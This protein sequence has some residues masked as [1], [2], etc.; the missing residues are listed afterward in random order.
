MRS[1]KNATLVGMSATVSCISAHPGLW[2]HCVSSA[3]IVQEAALPDILAWARKGLSTSNNSNASKVKLQWDTVA[4]V[5]HSRGGD[6]AYHQ[7]QL[8]DWVKS[9]VLIDPVKQPN[10]VITS[11][12]KAHL[13]LGATS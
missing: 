10:E 2:E 12:A 11:T 8:F 13:V 5:G 1:T 4:V 9:A 3:E 7:L 6:V